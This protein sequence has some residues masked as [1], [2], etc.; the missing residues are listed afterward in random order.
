MEE[1]F[2]NYYKGLLGTSRERRG[3]ICEAII[4]NGPILSARNRRCCLDL[5][6]MMKYNKHSFL[7][8][9]RNHLDQM[10]LEHFSLKMLGHC[11]SGHYCRSEGFFHLW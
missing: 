1:T 5:F 3:T 10:V 8:Q 2:I 11:G 7:F 9:V 6:L 4:A